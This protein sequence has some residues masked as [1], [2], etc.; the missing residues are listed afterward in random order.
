MRDRL[1]ARSI[2]TTATITII[3][4]GLMFHELY[5]STGIT[6]FGII[7]P[8][9]ESKWEHWKI[10]FF[11]M[12]IIGTLEYFI[13]KSGSVNYI[14]SLAVGII[15]FQIITFGSIELYEMI[16]IESHF[17]VHFLSFIIG[18]LGGQFVRYKLMESIKFGD[19]FAF[20]GV[21][22]I[23]V[24]IALFY[25]FTFNPPKTDYFKDSL[26]KTYGIYRET[27]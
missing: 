20:L 14:F 6:F 23:I 3:V 22:V 4:V 17:L 11:P 12:L 25:R 26:S 5:K 2:Y 10:A 21:I 13:V 19:G 8:V 18:A 15:V 9:N 27:E 24:Q 7:S 16:F 1:P